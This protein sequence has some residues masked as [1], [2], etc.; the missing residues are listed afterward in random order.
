MV[1]GIQQYNSLHSQK[2]R[3]NRA[4]AALVSPFANDFHP[5]QTL[6]QV[7]DRNMEEILS[8]TF[9]KNQTWPHKIPFCNELCR[10]HTPIDQ[11]G[12]PMLPENFEKYWTKMKE[13][14]A[15]R[16]SGRHVGVYKTTVTT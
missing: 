11:I 9:G 1:N 14:I 8:G 13:S 16:L 2:A 3:T 12:A 10:I 15:L 6:E 4:T 7:V 5:F